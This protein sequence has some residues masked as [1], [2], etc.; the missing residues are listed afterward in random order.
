M[1]RWMKT[2]TLKPFVVYSVLFGLASLT[3]FGIF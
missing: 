2:R 3:R 1:T